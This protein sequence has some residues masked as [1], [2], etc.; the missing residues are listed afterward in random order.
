MT[1][2]A[3]DIDFNNIEVTAT[4]PISN[5]TCEVLGAYISDGYYILEPDDKL[6]CT[7]QFFLKAGTPFYERIK[8]A[9]LKIQQH[10]LVLNLGMDKHLIKIIQ[11]ERFEK[12]ENGIY[13]SGVIFQFEDTLE[14]F[15]DVQEYKWTNLE[16]PSK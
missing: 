16:R 14:F 8:Q 13:L 1:P 3:R 12:D 2:R 15:E 4:D 10:P 7:A 5:G 9:P 6:E 11:I